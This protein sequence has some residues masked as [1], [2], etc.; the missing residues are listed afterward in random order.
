MMRSVKIADLKNRLRKIL[1]VWCRE[2]L[3]GMGL[4]NW[5]G[6][7]ILLMLAAVGVLALTLV[8]SAQA[9]MESEFFHLPSGNIGCVLYDSSPRYLRCDIRGGLKP[10]PSRL[11]PPASC[12]LDWGD[13]VTLSPTGRTELTCHGDTVLFVNPRSKVLRYGTTWT[14]GPYTCTSRTTGLT[15]KNTAGHGFFLSLQSWRRF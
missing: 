3:M 7:R 12:D 2:H 13:S 11:S 15:C 10:K 5:A 4:Y 1:R 14:R 9:E 8:G 6:V